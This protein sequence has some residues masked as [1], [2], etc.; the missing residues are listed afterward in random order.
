M[1]SVLI[2]WTYLYYEMS[3][4]VGMTMVKKKERDKSQPS[5]LP[6]LPANTSPLPISRT[7]VGW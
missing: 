1:G 4:Y 3:S 6:I 7:Y 5:I 2:N